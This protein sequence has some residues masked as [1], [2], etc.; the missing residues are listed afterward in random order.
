MPPVHA[1]QRPRFFNL[2]LTGAEP[3]HGHFLEYIMSVTNICVQI[4]FLYGSYL[5][6][7]STEADLA[8]GDTLFIIG[9][10]I[11]FVFAAYNLVES[12]A[13]WMHYASAEREDRIEFWETT[14]FFF[15]GLVFLVGSIFFWPGIYDWWYDGIDQSLINAYEEEGEAHGAKCFIAGSVMFLIA[16]M[17][18]GIGLGM[19]KNEAEENPVSVVTHYIHIVALLASQ[20]GSVLFVAGSVMYRPI[21]GG[22]C[23]E[24]TA[25]YAGAAQAGQTV[26]EHECESTGEYGTKLYIYGSALYLLEAL[27]NFTNSALKHQYCNDDKV[28]HKAEQ[29]EMSDIED[30]LNES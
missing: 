1:A 12:R 20:L 14:M 15:A 19:N 7:S 18:N 25:R 29:V 6:L 28:G 10:V 4:A 22:A 27:L 5:F 3:Q 13:H 8:F 16:S 26:A 11:T 23:A 21:L 24:F 9:S 30:P 2:C 17:F